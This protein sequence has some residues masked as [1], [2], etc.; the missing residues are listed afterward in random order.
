LPFA[1]SARECSLAILGESVVTPSRG[2]G[3][4]HPP[5]RDESLALQAPQRRIHGSLGEV[6]DR[7]GLAPQLCDELVAVHLSLGKQPQQ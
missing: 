1:P 2:V 3:E 5:T 6:D 7:V 4:L